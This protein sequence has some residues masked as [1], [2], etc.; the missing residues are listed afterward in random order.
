MDIILIAGG[1][2]FDNENVLF[3][4]LDHVKPDEVVQGGAKGADREGKLWA[5]FFGYQ[6]LQFDAEW[7][8]HGKK[9]GILRNIDMKNYLVSKQNE[10]KEVAAYIFWDGESKGTKNMIDLIIKSKIN[11]N[12][13]F[14]AKK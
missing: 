6:N 1:R 10:G 4:V 3:E 9:A 8:T 14:Y 2:D 12:I 5:D 11:L 7:D 13:T